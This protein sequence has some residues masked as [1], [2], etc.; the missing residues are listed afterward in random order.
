MYKITM[1]KLLIIVRLFAESLFFPFLGI[2]L[3]SKEYTTAQIGVIMGLIPICAIVCAPI[4]SKVFNNPKRVKRALTIMS[5]IEASLIILLML[6]NSNYYI[7]IILI[8]LIGI[9]SSSNYGM[10]DSLLTLVCVENNKGFAGVRALGSASYLIGSLGS[11]FIINYINHEVIFAIA[12]ICFISVSIIYMFVKAPEVNTG[13][14]TKVSIKTIL[15]NKAFIGYVIF[16]VLLIGS[17]QVGDDFYSIYLTSLGMKPYVYSLVMFGFISI[18]IIVLLILNKYRKINISLYF[19]SAVVLVI[20]AFIQAIPNINPYL[21]IA[22]QLSRGVIWGIAIFLST[23]YI[24][25]LLGFNNSTTG[26][27]LTT[28]CISVF[29]A[30]FKL[31]GG[32]IIDS[33]GYPKFYLILAIIALVA[34]IY[35][36]FYYILMKRRPI[37]ELKPE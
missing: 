4:Y 5:V 30:I 34:L 27:V 1:A 35:F 11:G 18:E 8:I 3:A 20:R 22:S 16:Y 24:V 15:K 36:T 28:F 13:E 21:L 32:Y 14:K 29:S 25:K 37:E 9:S 17:M 7:V 23:Q 6:F 2:F 12:A 19:V 31:C 33:I 10:L 26:I